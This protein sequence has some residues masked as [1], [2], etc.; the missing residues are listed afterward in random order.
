MSNTTRGNK[1][2]S[3]TAGVLAATML[4]MTPAAASAQALSRT[5]QAIAP[6]AAATAVGDIPQLNSALNQG[7]DAGLTVSEAK[8]VLVQLYAYAGF[9]RSLNALGELMKVVDARKQRGV[10]D[11]PG[12]DPSAPP[13]TGKELL[14][15]GTANQTRLSGAPVRGP[16]FEF[17]PQVDEYLKTH[18][19]GD[20]FG[21]DNL[22]WQSREVATVS[23]LAAMTG[24]ESQLQSH[25]R[26]S[27]NVGLTGGQLRQLADV[28]AE[29]GQPEAARR[30]RAAIQQVAPSP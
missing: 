18:L 24:V 25:I 14:A 19:F 17:A 9:P 2:M 27:L 30:T 15:L 10:Q 21:R 20:I 12:R 5:Q 16:L 22:D 13:P 23:A 1:L 4:A 7:L 8:E 28:L 26:I 3:L 6:I 29:R 11:T